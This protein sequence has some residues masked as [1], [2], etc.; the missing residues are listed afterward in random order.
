MK[1]IE[2]NKNNNNIN[3][4]KDMKS[5][6]ALSK[7]KN[8]E[9]KI[10]KSEKIESNKTLL[11]ELQKKNSLKEIS[12]KLNLAVGTVQR[13]IELDNIPIHYHFDLLRLLSKDVDYKNYKSSQKDQFF[14][15]VDIAE[16][17]WD[18][19]KEITKVTLNEYTFIE[20][21]AG[22]G[23]FFKLLPEKSIGLDIE[24]RCEK[25]I[26]K[27]Y[28]TWKPELNKKYIVVGNPPFGLRGHTALNFINH[29]HS[30]ADYVAFILPQLFESDGKG[31]PRKRVQGY[32]LIYSE[33]LAGL[34]H[35]P[36]KTEVE[37]NGVFQI[38]SKHTSNKEFDLESNKNDKLTIYSL[39]DGGTVATTRNK[40]MLDKCDIYLPSTCF[41]K[42]AMKLYSSF[43]SLPNRK[44]YGIVFKKDKKKMIEKS[45]KI[46]WSEIAFLS[47]NS[48]YN[49]RTSLITKAL[50]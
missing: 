6:D 33:K 44:G 3:I 38:W 2:V 4:D 8:K 36:D 49:L 20:P 29:S 21:S 50:L 35:T 17:C 19:F 41:G 9:I 47:T 34:F 1:K 11:E 27:D 5:N 28:L 37:I 46:D 13:W 45:K 40:N 48:A 16:K 39:S 42:D 25:I 26:K 10:D 23:S 31:S 30:F 32:N 22:D 7:S 12:V 43:E 18:K 15:P 24:P 14:T